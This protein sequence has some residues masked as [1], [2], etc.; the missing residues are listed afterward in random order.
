MHCIKKMKDSYKMLQQSIRGAAFPRGCK[1]TFSSKCLAEHISQLSSIKRMGWP[2][3]KDVSGLLGQVPRIKH[4]LLTLL[5]WLL[6]F[7]LNVFFFRTASS[8]YKCHIFNE[9]FILAA[10]VPAHF[11]TLLVHSWV[12]NSA[13]KTKNSSGSL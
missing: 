2:K 7:S 13:T 3:T 4:P 6:Q 11:L 8:F 5:S 9:T 12:V 1:N 10:A